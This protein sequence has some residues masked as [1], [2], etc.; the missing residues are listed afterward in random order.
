ME[1]F[2]LENS[3][4]YRKGVEYAASLYYLS[5]F[6]ESVLRIDILGALSITG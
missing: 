3:S 6:E 1:F 2:S 4:K 5:L